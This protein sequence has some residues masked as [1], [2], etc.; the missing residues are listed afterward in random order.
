MTAKRL[1][2]VVGHFKA[3]LRHNNAEDDKAQTT[4]KHDWTSA[5][6]PLFDALPAFKNFPGCAWGVWGAEDELGTV[7]FL[8]ETVVKLAASEEIR[9]GGLAH[10]VDRPLNFP[11]KP[12]FARK[13]PEINMTV[14]EPREVGVRD[15]EIHINTQSGTQWDGLRHVP[16][17]E[18]GT[19]LRAVSSRS[20]IRASST[21]RMP[22][23]GIQN[24]ATHGICGRGVLLDL[25]AYQMS[26]STGK[27][28]PYDPWSTHAISVAQL[29]ACAAAQGVEFRRG[30]ILLLR[31][32][33]IKK[34]NEATQAER[35]ALAE[36]KETFAGIEQSL[37]MKRFLW[38][39]HFAAVASDQPALEAMLASAGRASAPDDPRVLWG[40][41]I[42]EFFDLEKLAEICAETGRYTFFFS[43]WPLNMR[44]RRMRVAAKRS[45]ESPT[46]FAFAHDKHPIT[47]PTDWTTAPL[48]SYDELPAFKNFPG[49]AWGVWGMDDQLGTINLLT[50]AVVQRSAAEHIRTGKTVSLNCPLNF[51]SKPMFG[52][53]PPTINYIQKQ[54]EG[55]NYSRDDEIHINTQS[56]SQ[57]DGLRHFPILEHETFY[58]NTPAVDLPHGVIPIDGPEQIDASMTR[59]GIQNWANHGICGRG[60]LLDL[61]AFHTQSAP[62]GSDVLPYDPWTTHAITVAVLEACAQ[63]QQVEFRR[64]D[65]LIL[66]V[67]FTRRYYAATQ[68]ERDGLTGKPE[69]FAGIEQ[70]EDMKRF[71]WNNHFAAIASDMPSMER[72]PTPEGV[73]HMHQG[74]YPS[75]TFRKLTQSSLW[76]MPIGEMFDLEKLSQVCAEYNR[77]TFFVSSWPLNIIGGAASPPNAAA[78]F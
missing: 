32:G 36:V 10:G 26:L 57:W 37:E 31:V 41:P 76:G 24:W 14:R 78:F 67:G 54:K 34:Y 45:S 74:K 35:D 19:R 6:L 33:F 64:G 42:G 18:H 70:S 11:E 60:V 53:L 47:M 17:I 71:L 1:S 77:Y 8:T 39:N 72:W 58:N 9:L 4:R 7:N 38:N 73:P 69:T 2:L 16:M 27:T 50:D 12:M 46:S 65:I 29:E 62:D 20:P 75:V 49:C 25:V 52:R 23:L 40:M 56:G 15:D 55:R 22:S 3:L 30:D 21:P 44:N 48:P 5:P 59:I 28:L 51:P 61:V 43:S 63:A 68:E 66:R 13:A